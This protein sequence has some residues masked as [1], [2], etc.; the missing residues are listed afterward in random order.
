MNNLQK[1]LKHVKLIVKQPRNF[2]TT[3]GLIFI[4][5]VA[6]G[7]IVANLYYAQT[8]LSPIGHSINLPPSLIGFIVTFIQW[9]YVVGLLFIV[10]LVDFTENRRLIITLLCLSCFFL[11]GLAFIKTSMIFLLF[12]FLLGVSLVAPPIML[13]FAS[14][15]LPVEKHG[16]VI[17]KIM[18]GALFGIMFARP[19][20]SGL[21]EIFSWKAVF[22]FS[23]IFMAILV[24]LFY[25]LLPKR[26]PKHQL[27][28]WK[29][30]SSMP[31]IFKSYPVLR[32]RA[33]Y[34]A[35]LFGIF[36][37]FWSSVAMLLS[38]H[39]FHYSQG[40][41]ALF[42]FAGATGGFAAP[43]AGRIGDRG[44]IRPGTA[45]A[46]I[47]VIVA[48]IIA[49]ISGE[50]SVIALVISALLL[51]IGVAGNVVLGQKAL[52]SL[53]PEIRGRLNSLY[54]ASFFMGGA[55]G[56]AMAGY[57]F[58]HWGWSYITDLGVVVSIV[59]FI[60]F[61]SEVFSSRSNK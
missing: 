54:V 16:Q 3:N 7:G 15:I 55:V 10:P 56:S 20:A 45:I 60:Y 38:N 50:H 52:F 36:C 9:G 12:C 1:T 5:A 25:Y 42:A 22:I 31:I 61:L 34:H 43:I 23:V 39:I 47:I 6:S 28:Y 48:F 35:M 40:Q 53:E 11:L 4:F 32:R 51:D 18:S 14:H 26:T 2:I 33:L 44:W 37:L 19:L 49:K 24:G 21:T 57:L 8:L 30:L 17:G 27:S 41:I 59:T 46:I 29:L 13:P 58:V